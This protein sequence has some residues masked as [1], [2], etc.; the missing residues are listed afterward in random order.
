M[1]MAVYVQPPSPH[2]E[3]LLGLGE[4][5][6]MDMCC[7]VAWEK[8]NS[9]TLFKCCY[10]DSQT[11]RFLAPL[12]L[13]VAILDQQEKQ[14]VVLDEAERTIIEADSRTAHCLT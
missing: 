12:F 13:S 11:T 14:T 6:E 9:R 5:Y 4:Q 1:Q 3:K 2:D 8:R 7:S 10:C